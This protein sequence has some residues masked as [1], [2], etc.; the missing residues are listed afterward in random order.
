[1]DN[2]VHVPTTLI[3][4]VDGLR[5]RELH[6]LALLL[7]KGLQVWGFVGGQVLWMLAP[8]LGEPSVAPLAEALESPEALRRLESRLF[9]D[10][11]VEGVGGGK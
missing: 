9:E 2:D 5:D 3:R 1:M 7:V 8:F 11:P 4:W 10:M 6:G